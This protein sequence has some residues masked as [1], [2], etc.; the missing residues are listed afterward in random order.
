ME[1]GF[2]DKILTAMENFPSSSSTP[3]FVNQYTY[4]ILMHVIL[5]VM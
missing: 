2:T 5:L 3:H 1:S 4:T